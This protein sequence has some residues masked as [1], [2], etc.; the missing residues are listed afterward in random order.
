MLRPGGYLLY[1]TCTFSPMEDEATVL[2][3]LKSDSSL[4]VVDMEGYEGFAPGRPD[5]I[6]DSIEQLDKCVRIYPHKMEGEGHFLALLHK[7]DT[8]VISND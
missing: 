2:K 1:S 4:Q 3:M 5:M 7:E 6:M 8:T